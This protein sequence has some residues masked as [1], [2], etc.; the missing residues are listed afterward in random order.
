MNLI[1]AINPK[2]MIANEIPPRINPIAKVPLEKLKFEDTKKPMTDNP[3][4][5]NII[6]KYPFANLLSIDL[7]EI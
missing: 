6:M 5:T 2:I 4:Y 3:E 1:K 7:L